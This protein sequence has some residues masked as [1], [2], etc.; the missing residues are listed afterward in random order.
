MDVFA[1]HFTSRPN[2]IGIVTKDGNHSQRA[3]AKRRGA[4]AHVWPVASN[5]RLDLPEEIVRELR[6]LCHRSKTL[7]GGRIR[8]PVSR[9]AVR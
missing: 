9:A 8:A 3:L 4:H 2:V 5:E 6:A 1:Q 7:L